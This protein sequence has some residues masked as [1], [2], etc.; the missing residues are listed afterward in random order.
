MPGRRCKVQLKKDIHP[1]YVE[2]TVTCA[3]GS[4]FTTRSTVASMKL[5]LCSQCHPFYTGKQKIVDTEGRVERFRQRYGARRPGA[6][7]E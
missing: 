1:N 7:A 3:C 6:A 5:D 2:C 4:T